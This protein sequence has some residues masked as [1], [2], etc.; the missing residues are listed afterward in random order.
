VCGL[1]VGDDFEL[2]ESNRVRIPAA[3]RRLPSCPPVGAAAPASPSSDSRPAVDPLEQDPLV[4]CPDPR[5]RDHA[6]E[7]LE[8]RG[9]SRRAH[10]SRSTP[11]LRPLRCGRRRERRRQGGGRRFS[12]RRRERE[13]S[14]ASGPVW[15]A[16]SSVEPASA[17][18]RTNASARTPASRGA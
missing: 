2:S 5:L 4:A 12:G 11:P 8:R 14:W 15:K 16:S 18:R 1:S 17:A 10:M 9:L 3:P 6:I 7:C 13:P